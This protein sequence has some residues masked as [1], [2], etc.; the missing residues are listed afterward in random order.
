LGEEKLVAA[1]RYYIALVLVV[2]MLP[3]LLVWPLI[4]PLIHFWR[5]LGPALASILVW[6][7]LCLIGVGL[8]LARRSLLA[9]DFGTNYPLI[10]LGALL[11]VACIWLWVP[12]HRYLSFTT[13]MGLP[14]LAPQKYPTAL[15]TG[16]IY[17]RM[18]HPR[19]VQILLFLWGYALIANYP[20]AYAVAALWVPGILIIV[21]LEEKELRERYGAA[22]EEY[23]RGVPRFVPKWGR[24]K[25]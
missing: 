15:I 2:T 8:F 22:Y 12:L 17:S 21:R 7:I 9:W 11:E 18:R 10:V 4:H 3:M 16:G 20:A 25:D 24:G 14:E 13:M 23:C 1:V 6:T 19:Y 5:R